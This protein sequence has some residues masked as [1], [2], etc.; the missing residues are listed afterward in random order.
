MQPRSRRA[1]A[2]RGREVS[3]SRAVPTRVPSPNGDTSSVTGHCRVPY[4]RARHCPSPSWSGAGTWHGKKDT[5]AQPAPGLRG[6]RET[7]PSRVPAWVMPLVFVPS[8]RAPAPLNA[9]FPLFLR[10]VNAKMRIWGLFPFGSC[11]RG[12]G[13]CLWHRQRRFP[14]TRTREKCRSERGTKKRRGAGGDNGI[15][16]RKRRKEKGKRIQTNNNKIKERKAERC[17]RFGSRASPFL[18]RRPHNDSSPRQPAEGLR[19]AAPAPRPVLTPL[20][21]GDPPRTPNPPPQ[22]RLLQGQAERRGPFHSA[23]QNRDGTAVPSVPPAP[24]SPPAGP[25]GRLGGLGKGGVTAL[26]SRR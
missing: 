18:L 17:A 24:L 7:S 8:G 4:P 15:T 19:P 6:L 14:V 12:D 25:G 9:R 20:P 13:D 10:V 22:S 2:A 1:G 26:R 5:S 23:P 11:P 3:R 16:H 21:H